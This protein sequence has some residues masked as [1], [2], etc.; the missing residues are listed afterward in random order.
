MGER[1]LGGGGSE[2]QTDRQKRYRHM[3]R[4]SNEREGGEK[5]IGK[6]D[7]ESNDRQRYRHMG[8]ESNEREREGVGW[9]RQTD[10]WGVRVMRERDFKVLC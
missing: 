5:E 2:R 6:I 8:R 3:R 1:V 4:E 7:E 10:R 9:K